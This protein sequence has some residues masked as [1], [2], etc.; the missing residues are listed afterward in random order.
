MK[1]HISLVGGP[2]GFAA[3]LSVTIFFFPT[4]ITSAQAALKLTLADSLKT[5][6]A[7][8]D[9]DLKNVKFSWEEAKINYN[10]AWVNYQIMSALALSTTQSKTSG[11]PGGGYSNSYSSALSLSKKFPILYSSVVT[12]SASLGIN[13]AAAGGTSSVTTSPALSLTWEQP[14]TPR[15]WDTYLLSLKQAESGLITAGYSYTQT[16]EA[17]ALA[18]CEAFFNLLKAE[19]RLRLTASQITLTKDLVK[20]TEAK[21]KA[22]LIP[23]LDLMRA[24]VQLASDQD[25]LDQLEE[26][27]SQQRADFCRLLGLKPGTEI[28]LVEDDLEAKI[29][30]SEEES[31][32]YALKNR[33][34]L[35][36]LAINIADYKLNMMAT[37]GGL[38]PVLNVSGNY[39]K[40]GVGSDL[41]Q[42]LAGLGNDN[43]FVTASLDFTFLDG[44]QLGLNVSQSRIGLAR[45]LI[46]RDSLIRQIGDQ[47]RESYTSLDITRRRIEQLKT[48]LVL[49]RKAYEVSQLRYDKGYSTNREVLEAQYALAQTQASLEDAEVDA[50][51]NFVK[52]K[53]QEGQ[54]SRWL[55][56]EEQPK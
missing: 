13:Q 51:S 31:L 28:S 1:K 5:A 10:L 29:G 54:L 12:T 17:F 19:R 55:K 52:F 47:I 14:L 35:K 15:R 41:G 53:N 36:A 3:I 38:D 39:Q 37:E 2:L 22:G 27:Y 21:L 30:Y 43:I 16:R 8:D 46:S 24:Q 44:G 11:M 6:L 56:I 9:P 50:Q 7:G 48:S 34:D 18:V 4:F 40:T 26:N 25:S 49:A 32:K 33:L 42:S 23:E 20:M 45:I